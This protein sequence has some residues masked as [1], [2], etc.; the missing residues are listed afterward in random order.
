MASPAGKPHRN[1]PV[2]NTAV[3]GDMKRMITLRISDLLQYPRLFHN[4]ILG[5][6]QFLGPVL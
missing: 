1:R 4:E 5:I 2:W 3:H 6:K